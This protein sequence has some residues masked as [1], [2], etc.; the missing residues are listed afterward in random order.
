M[1]LAD[2][3]TW[4]IR[5]GGNYKNLDTAVH[6][7]VDNLLFNHSTWG[8]VRVGVKDLFGSL[9]G[10]HGSCHDAWKHARAHDLNDQDV[11]PIEAASAKQGWELALGHFQVE[12]DKVVRVLKALW[13]GRVTKVGFDFGNFLM[14]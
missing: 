12:K 3:Q 4:M 11:H 5:E 1:A 7:F 14:A 13:R 2:L 9:V 8:D 6:A 10:A